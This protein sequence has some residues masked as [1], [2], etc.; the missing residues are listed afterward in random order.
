MPQ[1][2]HEPP[3]AELAQ[4]TTEPEGSELSR[5]RISEATFAGIL[6]ISSDAVVSV[7]E[8]HRIVMF[9]K[10]AEQIFGYAAEE[11]LGQPLDIV[12][13]ERARGVHGGHLNEFS[14]ARVPARRM[15]ERGEI[16]GRRKNGDTF[17]AEASISKIDVGG[18]RIF[19]A[20]LRDITD[21]HRAEQALRDKNE[22]LARQN[23]R[24]EEAN[25][26]K[27]EFLAN[28][29][30]ELRTPLNAI[31]GFA[32]L[33]HDG[34]A[35]PVTAEQRE[36][37]GDVLTSSRHLLQLINDVLDLSKVEAGKIELRPELVDLEQLVGEVRDILRSI[38]GAK[39][40]QVAV[41]IAPAIRIG[42]ADPAKL[43][44]V[45]YNY[46]SNALKFT[47]EGGR[48]SVRVQPTG[49]STGIRLEVEDSGIGIKAEDI[50]RLFVEFQQL[51]A[52]TAKKYP[53]T[54]LGL[55]L[56]KRLVEAQGGTVGVRSTAGT[57]SV[58][59][60]ELPWPRE[61]AG[62]APSS[63]TE[64]EAAAHIL[65]IDDNPADAGWLVRTLTAAGYWSE[66]APTGAEALARCRDHAYDA[67][68][69]DLVLP[70]L[71]GLSVLAGIRAA[72]S[73]ATTPVFIV[74]LA[75]ERG[76]GVGFDVREVLQKPVRAEDLVAALRHADVVPRTGGNQVFA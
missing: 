46:L 37:L 5:L 73:N 60:A 15:G 16:S 70:D 40:I 59:F 43:K 18:R 35:G 62:R 4:T 56:T 34:R 67:I 30:H 55:A 23:R 49:D 48:V 58:F 7:D 11:V 6:S 63:G 45:L 76:V 20:V 36:Y 12:I 66:V 39:R 3:A 57:G 38:A 42:V 10:G 17:P 32:E 65:V 71:D 75:R 61:V 47:A 54:G 19:T 14:A 68:L 29:S 25:R 27:S 21:R 52:S 26:L 72:T 64:R 69:L 74:T 9:N 13:P 41:T 44:Q 24:V 1:R 31:I 53:G 33:L 2:T 50:D 51:D 28:M 8:A 22:E